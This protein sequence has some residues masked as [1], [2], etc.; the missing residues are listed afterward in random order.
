MTKAA[1]KGN[2]NLWV[3]HSDVKSIFVI[4]CINRLRYS[5]SDYNKCVRATLDLVKDNKFFGVFS[6]GELASSGEH[7]LEFF[8]KTIVLCGLEP[9]L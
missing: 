6:L 7:P 1:T 4:D 9:K 8:T 2:K 3:K 5:G